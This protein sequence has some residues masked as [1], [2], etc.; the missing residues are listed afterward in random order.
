MPTFLALSEARL[1]GKHGVLHISLA[2]R[3]IISAKSC[4]Q[5]RTFDLPAYNDHH[6]LASRERGL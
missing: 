3:P 2:T 5:V 1:S 6:R 4:P